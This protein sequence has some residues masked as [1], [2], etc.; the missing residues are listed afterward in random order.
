M[1]KNNLKNT[2]L[3]AI[4]VLFVNTRSG[5]GADVA[6]HYMLIRNFLPREAVVMLA[7]NRLAGDYQKTIQMLRNVPGIRIVSLNMGYEQAG[8]GRFSR[9]LGAAGNLY[10]LFFALL[11]LCWIVKR[12]GIQIIHSTDRPRD[13]LL[14]TLLARFTGCKNIVH[15]H[16]KWYPE[17]GKITTRALEKASGVL[18][19][20]KFVRSSLIEG[21]VDPLKIYTEWNATDPMEFNP[22]KCHRGFLH[23]KLDLAENVP[24]VGIVARVMVWKGH[25]ELV[26]AFAKVLERVPEAHLVI[27]GEE[28]LLA[29]PEPGSYAA[30]VRSLIEKMG[31][32]EVV[33]WMGW[34][35]DMPLVFADLDVVCVPS[36]E[37]PFGLVVTEAM[38]MS[39]PVVGF[40]SGA[41]PEI[42]DSG[43]D[44]LLVTQK[45]VV[46][47]AQSITDLLQSPVM[48]NEIGDHARQK[49]LDRFT[50]R[51][52]ASGV[53]A[54][55]RAILNG[56][57]ADDSPSMA[58]HEK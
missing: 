23:N 33:H 55:Y 40:N 7:T 28:D 49:V 51:R 58:H 19:I 24:L 17:I 37:E 45:D 46:Q 8:K 41:L 30:S 4:R 2:D 1:V 9:I 50:P 21:G 54:I 27:V 10:A 29:S 5:I 47:L 32:E 6:V 53:T 44:G 18:A 16:I 22:A 3:N 20:S 43:V 56:V 34:I 13:A 26:K 15:V 25:L 11:Q 39:R 12:N 14:S 57:P 36:W 52:Q 38:S 42:I 48:A 35:D 31:L